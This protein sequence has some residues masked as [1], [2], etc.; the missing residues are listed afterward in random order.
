M[1]IPDIQDPSKIKFFGKKTYACAENALWELNE[2]LEAAHI[3]VAHT[4]NITVMEQ[5]ENALFVGYADGALHLWKNL[6]DKRIKITESKAPTIKGELGDAPSTPIKKFK[7]LETKH[8][9]DGK[10]ISALYFS[11]NTFILG[12]ANGLLV[13]FEKDIISHRKPKQ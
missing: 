5:K 11:G 2:N 7:K 9:K 13:I 1:S 12:G 4:D 3:K 6:R 8:F 10:A